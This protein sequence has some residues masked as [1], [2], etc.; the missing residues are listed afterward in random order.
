MCYVIQADPKPGFQPRS[1]DGKY[2]P[3]FRGKIWV[4]RESCNGRRSIWRWWTRF[5]WVVCGP[6][7]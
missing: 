6:L 5:L 3:K 7:E 2:L 4:T 1:K